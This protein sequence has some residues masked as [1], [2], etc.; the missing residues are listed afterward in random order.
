[1]ARSA[2]SL[3]AVLCA[4]RAQAPASSSSFFVDCGA[5][6]DSGGDG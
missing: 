6:S 2:L 4:A 3:A 1:M 5:G